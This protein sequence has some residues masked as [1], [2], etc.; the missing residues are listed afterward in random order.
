[1]RGPEHWPPRVRV[2]AFDL[3][4]ARPFTT[5]SG[6]YTR[7]RGWLVRIG[8]ASSPPVGYGE[9]APLPGHGG[10]PLADVRPAI[11]ALARILAA[12]PPPG[13]DSREALTSLAAELSA[14]VPHAPCAVAAVVTALA[15]RAARRSGLPLA[16]W[17]DASATAG[18]DVNATIGAVPPAEA[19]E[20]ARA[21]VAAGFRTLKL[22]MGDGPVDIARA[23]AV[24]AA[25]GP[26]VRLRGDANGGWSEDSARCK[27][28]ALAPLDLAFVEQPTAASDVAALARLHAWSPVPIAADEALLP[29]LGPGAEALLQTQAASVWVLKPALLGGPFVAMDLAQRAAAAGIEVVITTALDAAVGRRMA[30]HVASAITGRRHADGL[31]TAGF[32]AEDVGPDTPIEAGRVHVFDLGL[33]DDA[34]GCFHGLGSVPAVAIDRWEAP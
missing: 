5:A 27:L 15:D 22:K 21:A 25:V 20:R 16:R 26:T 24:R 12:A 6:V 3:P 18:V 8:D 19:A 1:M 33:A 17:L 7:R 28:A 34:D 32:L 9:A 2:T 13:D 10:E 4:F 30:M 11:A 23:R 14:A 29:P 31:A